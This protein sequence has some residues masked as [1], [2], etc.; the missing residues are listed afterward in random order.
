MHGTYTDPSVARL[1]RRRKPVPFW[2]WL[3]ALGSIFLVT[4]VSLAAFTSWSPLHPLETP[5]ERLVREHFERQFTPFSI[6]SI[7][8][9]ETPTDQR[10]FVALRRPALRGGTEVE[11]HI[12][13]VEDGKVVNSLP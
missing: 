2:F 1:T 8:L 9:P 3:V 13:W 10:W 6:E 7:R 11:H 5:E 4:I 12:L